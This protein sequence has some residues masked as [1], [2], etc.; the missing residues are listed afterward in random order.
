MKVEVLAKYGAYRVIRQKRGLAMQARAWGRWHTLA[1]GEEAIRRWNRWAPQ[2]KHI[3]PNNPRKR[4][5]RKLK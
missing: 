3:S 4:K 2:A 1:V 5:N